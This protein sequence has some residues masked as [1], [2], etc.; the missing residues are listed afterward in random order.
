[1]S[2]NED[3]YFQVDSRL[4]IQLGENLVTNKST[5]LAELIKN[6][7]DADATKVVIR[8]KNIKSSG[9]SLEIIDN[10][11]GMSSDRFRKTWM[12]IGTADKEINPISQKFKRA[13]AGEK[14]IGRFACRLLSDNLYIETISINED[15]IKEKIQVKFDW[16]NFISGSNVDNI[17]IKLI[18]TAVKQNIPTGTKIY[19]EK[20]KEGWLKREITQMRNEIRILTDPMNVF[21]NIEDPNDPLQFTITL[22]I[23]E[24]PESEVKIDDQLYTNSWAEVKGKID[25]DGNGFYRLST[26]SKILNDIDEYFQI[27][28][29]FQNLN[30]IEL[31]FFIFAFRSDL[32]KNSSWSFKRT[33]DYLDENSGIK[34]YSDNF[35]VFRYG[36]KGD[37]W[38]RLTAD[39]ARSYTPLSKDFMNLT[40]EDRPGLHLFRNNVL[41]G[42][43]KFSR[44]D[45]QK[46][47]ITSNRHDLVN[48]G[49][50][51]ELTK[52]TRN[53]VEFA[54]A[55]YSQELRKEKENEINEQQYLA[56]KLLEEAKILETEAQKEIL[57]ISTKASKNKTEANE[58]VRKA[59]VRMNKIN[60]ERQKIQKQDLTKFENIDRYVKKIEEEKLALQNFNEAIT[61]A[62]KKRSTASK[63]ESKASI[64]LV[65]VRDKQLD[66]KSFQINVDKTKL[67]TE[68][69]LYRALASTGTLIVIFQHE[70]NALVGNMGDI[71]ET[72]STMY[73][74]NLIAGENLENDI[75][76]FQERIKMVEEFGVFLGITI[77]KESITVKKSWTLKPI[78]DATFKPFRYY[79]KEY[80]IEIENE[81]SPVLRSPKMYR[82]EI[83]SIFHNLLSN[84][85]KAVKGETKRE[86]LIKGYQESKIIYLEFLDSGEGLEKDKW[87]LVFN[88][89]ESF[90][91]KDDVMG[92]GTGLGL[93]LVK[94]IVSSYNG[95][96]E[97]R[98]A[99]K[100]WK[101]RIFIQLPMEGFL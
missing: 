87:N 27:K 26:R 43:V 73:K 60:K 64:K 88:A 36:S 96:V 70:L 68:K 81:I 78:L 38:L 97:F 25:D 84:A 53:A 22:D 79:C 16:N 9:G 14:G 56:K 44:H 75:L 35:R 50:F 40:D 19:L 54:T 101:T 10:G 93:K 11:H 72:F 48:N 2:N 30:N 41:I 98:N 34:V 13:K 7:Y 31:Y 100:G 42:F 91:K 82:S 58:I 12:R 1:M 47:Q 49:A 69:V 85:M 37:D 17:P 77:G 32:F 39:R 52:Y 76:E 8:M 67:D 18:K 61:I 45:N 63:L 74:N 90:S 62:S 80:G 66:A 59:S 51:D 6:S 3:L 89:F 55:I 99:P 46:L 5:A 24:Y 29:P 21:L 15:N 71:V 57:E 65:E 83:T 92:A 23:P 86:I 20:L 4:L 28:I 95:E 94:D 33:R